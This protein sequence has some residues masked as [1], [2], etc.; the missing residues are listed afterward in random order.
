MLKSKLSPPEVQ[1]ILLNVASSLHPQGHAFYTTSQFVCGSGIANKHSTQ[2][3]PG[4]HLDSYPGFILYRD[5]ISLILK[6]FAS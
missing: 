3:V 2:F 5:T 4:P 1:Q 6:N